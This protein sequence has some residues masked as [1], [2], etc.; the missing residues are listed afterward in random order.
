MTK[1]E[2]LEKIV[3]ELEKKEKFINLLGQLTETKRIGHI[4]TNLSMRRRNCRPQ[5]T[6]GASRC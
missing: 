6:P 2:D 1:K 3:K 5:G 4:L